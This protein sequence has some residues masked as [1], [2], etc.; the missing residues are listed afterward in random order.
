[1]FLKYDQTCFEHT[2]TTKLA[3]TIENENWKSKSN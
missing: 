2:S 1:M 3:I